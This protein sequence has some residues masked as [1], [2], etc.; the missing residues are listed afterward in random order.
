M[1]MKT[2][3]LICSSVLA[4][5]WSAIAQTPTAPPDTGL[6]A[7]VAP[8]ATATP[9]ATA[10]P[11]A[12]TAPVAPAPAVVASPAT[13]SE[14]SITPAASPQ[15][16]DEFDQAIERKIRKHFSVDFGGSHT[17]HPDF[18]NPWWIAVIVLIGCAAFFGTPIAIVGLILYFGSSR[19]RNLH[20]TVRM[21]VEKG[22]PVPEALL[23][24]PPVVRRRSDLR[25]A[26]IL[27]VLGAGLMVFFGAVSDWEGGAWSLGFIP[28]IIGLGYLLVWKLDVRRE[29]ASPKV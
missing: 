24:P 22:Q 1:I 13:T 15:T 4:L 9:A 11:A 8:T 21:M 17:D 2:T 29:E 6:A 5:A 3:F 20:K 26:V 28:F 16:E 27:V 12:T 23:N 19:S 25:R 7:T 10:A 14:P 18:E